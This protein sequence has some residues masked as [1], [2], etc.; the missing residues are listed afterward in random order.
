MTPRAR[1]TGLIISSCTTLTEGDLSDSDRLITSLSFEIHLD[2]LK[3]ASFGIAISYCCNS[4]VSSLNFIDLKISL[5]SC[6]NFVSQQ[7]QQGTD[8][9]CLLQLSEEHNLNKLGRTGASLRRCGADAY[10][11]QTQV[12]DATEDTGQLDPLVGQQLDRTLRLCL[13]KCNL[14][15][16]ES[17][18]ESNE[19]VQQILATMSLDTQKQ[20]HILVYLLA[21]GENPVKFKLEILIDR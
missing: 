14:F 18:E 21:T 4:R 10:T 8:F 6:R 15:F 9:R 2:K 16:S 20:H 17:H 5:Y 7:G 3:P 1:S 11:T 12:T 19:I 13:Q